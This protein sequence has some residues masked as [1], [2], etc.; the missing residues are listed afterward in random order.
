MSS[1]VHIRVEVIK[2]DD[3]DG[4]FIIAATTEDGEILKQI[5]LRNQNVP[6]SCPAVQQRP[7]LFEA[8]P[9]GED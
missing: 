9:P 1:E 3:D 7:E 6:A 4:R 8:I 5:V 2:I